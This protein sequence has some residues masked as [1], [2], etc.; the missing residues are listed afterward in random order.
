M[1]SYSPSSSFAEVL[2]PVLAAIRFNTRMKSSW[3]FFGVYSASATKYE[4]SPIHTTVAVAP[5]VTAA[6]IIINEEQYSVC[7]KFEHLRSSSIECSGVRVSM[8]RITPHLE[9][10]H[11]PYGYS[12]RLTFLL[13][14]ERFC[15]V[16]INS[17]LLTV[18]FT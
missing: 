14:Q 18:N 16:Y 11:L 2:A 1:L 3:N 12:K 4:Q 6:I 5:K 17:M 8:P 7:T 15:E 9:L 10:P 13:L